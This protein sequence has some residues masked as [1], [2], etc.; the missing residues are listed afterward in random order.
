MNRNRSPISRD[1]HQAESRLDMF[2]E[3]L[4]NGLSIRDAAEASG[5]ARQS[6]DVMFARIRKKLGRQAC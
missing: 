4:A 2:A 3:H 6:G 1:K 5:V